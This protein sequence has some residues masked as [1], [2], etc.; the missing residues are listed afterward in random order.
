MRKQLTQYFGF[1]VYYN[2]SMFL[3]YFDQDDLDTIKQF[4]QGQADRLSEGWIPLPDAFF[5]MAGCEFLGLETRSLS[6]RLPRY[7]DELQVNEGYCSIPEEL[8]NGWRAEQQPEVYA[9]YY[10]VNI[11]RFLGESVEVN[12]HKFVEEMQ[13]GA[14]V[15]NLAWSDTIPEYRFDSEMRQQTFLSLLL[16]DNIDIAPIEENLTGGDFLASIYYSW[17]IRRLLDLSPSLKEEESETLIEL[18]K[19]GGFREYR[20][21]DKVDEHAGSNHRTFHDK[22]P[23]HLFSTIYGYQLAKETDA[24]SFSDDEL[25]DFVKEARNE[26]GFG[27]PVHARGFEQPFGPTCTPLENL[28]VL[29]LP[30]LLQE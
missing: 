22:N 20:L 7:I 13:N 14:W 12:L 28:M 17:R 18:N 11:L 8:L 3:D 2:E 26:D 16:S 29:L 19:K 30:S 15:Y 23:P 5:T 4:F 24:V 1:E 9:T 27:V 21:R 10:A 6:D 25:V